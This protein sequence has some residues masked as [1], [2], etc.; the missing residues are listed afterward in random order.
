[1]GSMF[2]S[3]S[4]LTTAFFSGVLLLLAMVC[5]APRD[6]AVVARMRKR[7]MDPRLNLVMGVVV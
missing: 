1:M 7:L 6:A 5:T 4:I 3:V 2:E